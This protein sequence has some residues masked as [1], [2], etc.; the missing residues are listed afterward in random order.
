MVN[1]IP[2]PTDVQ[3]L[4]ERKRRDGE[5]HKNENSN[6]SIVGYLR[7]AIIEPFTGQMGVKESQIFVCN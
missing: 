6:S 3:G 4:R 5:S 7:K 1:F 2:P